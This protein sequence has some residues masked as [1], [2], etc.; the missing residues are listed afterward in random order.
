MWRVSTEGPVTMIM[1]SR[2]RLLE[3]LGCIQLF[4]VSIKAREK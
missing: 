1:P 3:A 2:K 4:T